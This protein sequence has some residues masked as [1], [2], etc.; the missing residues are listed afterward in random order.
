[1]RPTSLLVDS[2]IAVEVSPRKT[3]ATGIFSAGMIAV[4]ALAFKPLMP[5]FPDG[6]MSYSYCAFVGLMIGVCGL[7]GDLAF[8]MIKRD[9]GAKDTGSLLPPTVLLIVQDT[10][11]PD[12]IC[13]RQMVRKFLVRH[14]RI[15]RKSKHV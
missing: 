1:M 6:K 13:G 4:I 2:R 12:V 8:S 15:S 7:F 14:R 10:L 11:H 3:W 9:L 5:P